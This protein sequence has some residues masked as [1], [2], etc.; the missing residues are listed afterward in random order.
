MFTRD[1]QHLRHASPPAAVLLSAQVAR[2]SPRHRDAPGGR[3]R[4]PGR[5]FSVRPAFMPQ[6]GAR[7][8][9][10]RGE[11]STRGGRPEWGEGWEEEEEEE[12][13]G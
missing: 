5:V 3:C 8:A 11:G 12:R 1:G 2:A 4:A 13:E 10:W 7:R 9:G 6:L